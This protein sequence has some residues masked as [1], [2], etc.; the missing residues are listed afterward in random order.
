M[1]C[2]E[3]DGITVISEIDSVE[4]KDTVSKLTL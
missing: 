1:I 3:C 2:K 4:Y